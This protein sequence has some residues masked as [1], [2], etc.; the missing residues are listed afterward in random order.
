MGEKRTANRKTPSNKH[1]PGRTQDASGPG[2]TMQTRSE[3]DRH[4]PTRGVPG[5]VARDGGLNDEGAVRRRKWGKNERRGRAGGA[6][7]SPTVSPVLR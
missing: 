4:A 6:P 5:R 2:R 1:P 7:L 3:T